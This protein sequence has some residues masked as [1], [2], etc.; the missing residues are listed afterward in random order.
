MRQSPV[1]S[2][3]VPPIRALRR[4]CRTG[5]YS[6]R[7]VGG[8]QGHG[9]GRH[10]KVEGR[11]RA[12]VEADGAPVDAEG[13]LAHGDAAIGKGQGRRLGEGDLAPVAAGREGGEIEA[14]RRL[15]RQAAA[16]VEVEASRL[17]RQH[18][19]ACRRRPR[20]V[21]PDL[22]ERLARDGRPVDGDGRID[23]GPGV[24]V[25]G[26]CPGVQALHGDVGHPDPRPARLQLHVLPAA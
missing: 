22:R 12:P 4:G 9:L 15:R 8:G 26:G 20:G 1:G 21:Q 17:G 19:V 5:R 13:Q 25:G 2:P 24:D 14:E 11:A 23:D 16:G 6:A 18:D 3:A 10:A 7:D